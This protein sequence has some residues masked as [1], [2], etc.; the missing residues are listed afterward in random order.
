M[1][2]RMVFAFD[3]DDITLVSQ[4]TVDV[5]VRGQTN[6]NIK[7]IGHF[8]DVFDASH[9]R[10]FRIPIRPHAFDPHI[11]LHSPDGPPTRISVG[12]ARGE[13]VI[14]LPAN[15]DLDHVK[16]VR[17]TTPPMLDRLTMDIANPALEERPLAHF[18][19][20]RDR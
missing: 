9:T 18:P 15:P 6:P 17:V 12:R 2:I 1:A 3:G 4:Q 11:E 20:A 14:M 5:F 8:V 19:L 7:G 13:F 16:V 10:L